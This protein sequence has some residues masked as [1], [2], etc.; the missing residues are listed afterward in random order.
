MFF[1]GNFVIIIKII[2][3]IFISTIIVIIVTWFYHTRKTFFCTSNKIGVKVI[4]AIATI[5]KSECPSVDIFP[6]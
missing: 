4:W 2:I 3:I 5:F 1:V 6:N